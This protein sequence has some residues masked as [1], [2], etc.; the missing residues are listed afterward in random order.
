[1]DYDFPTGNLVIYLFN[2]FDEKNISV[3][4]NKLK[5]LLAQSNAKII[6]IY[7]NPTCDK[8][9]ENN[10]P[11]KCIQDMKYKSPYG[12]KIYLFISKTP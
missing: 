2:P 12:W 3:I 5:N 8:Y 10:L 7:C 11:I 1:M 4:V 6:I 9:I